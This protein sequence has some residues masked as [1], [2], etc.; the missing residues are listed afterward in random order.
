MKTCRQLSFLRAR[1]HS[2]NL[3]DYVYT[4][5]WEMLFG[6]ERGVGQLVLKGLKTLVD[7]HIHV[8]KGQIYV[9]E[10]ELGAW[11]SLLIKMPPLPIIAYALF[12]KFRAV[13]DKD[14]D[15]AVTAH[16]LQDTALISTKNSEL[17]ELARNPG[18]YDLHIHLN[19]ST[20][21]DWIWQ[22]ALKRPGRFARFV[23]R[24]MAAEADELF[25]QIDERFDR[26]HLY[27]LLYAASDIRYWMAEVCYGAEP[28]EVEPVSPLP[29]YF[30]LGHHHRR[31]AFP[32]NRHP[33][34]LFQPNSDL[35][36]DLYREVRLL[37][38]FYRKVET[39]GV[40]AY[41]NILH[42]YLLIQSLLNRLLVQQAEQNGFDQ[43]E[44]IT[45]NAMRDFSEESYYHRR[46]NQV[47]GMY[48]ED[49][50]FLEG[51][52]AP[53]DK[54][55]KMYN[56]LRTIEKEYDNYSR[57]KDRSNPGITAGE[58]K[59]RMEMKLVGHFIKK[60]VGRYSCCQHYQLRESLEKQA[61][62]L[63]E[64]RSM[65]PAFKEMIVGC[66][67]AGNELHAPP[68]VFAPVFRRM[69]DSEM[70]NFTF[71]VGEDFNHIVSGIRA[72]YETVCFLELCDGNRL[73]HATAL[74][75]EP[76][77]WKRRIGEK[78]VMRRA[79]HLD[80]LV[81]TW[82]LLKNK[83]NFSKE[84]VKIEQEIRSHSKRIYAE[85]VTPNLL[86]QAWE[87]RSLNPVKALV[88]PRRA[89]LALSRFDRE[90]LRLIDKV[91]AENPAA[92][93][94]FSKYHGK[95]VHDLMWGESGNSEQ[96]IEIKTD[97]ISEKAIKELQ[98]QVLK[99]LVE[100]DVAI[101]SM[102]TS[103]FR[104]SCYENY[105]EHHI[106]RWLNLEKELDYPEPKVCIC[107]DDPGIFATNIRNEYTH[108]QAMLNKKDVKGKDSEDF[109]AKLLHNSKKYAF[110]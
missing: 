67:A 101:E 88:D 50:A 76:L 70:S 99:V 14:K 97:F 108:V 72:V 74:G 9:K 27:R 100:S 6:E 61:R 44:R 83:S 23:C 102:P 85:E 51:R 49:V 89:K 24:E 13:S 66:D 7:K 105:D 36:S 63:I 98:W 34:I 29:T 62:L 21:A 58:E 28:S 38:D 33:R 106:T 31:L 52:F 30:S 77:L 4:N 64:M 87:M 57:G 103:N 35:N 107:S 96:Y 69:R 47:E 42:Y 16:L 25:M 91:K 1:Q 40:P 86:L 53:K 8:E 84:V 81:F 2:S 22:D 39:C 75:L 80:D 11:Q 15:L 3:P 90:E 26:N 60:K 5:H 10:G 46:F 41:G 104:I 110:R 45:R 17:D 59:K 55:M 56:L 93:A 71:H 94:I 92:L 82:K 32:R 68:E 78:I 79:N 12:D 54:G 19:G 48:S 73:G 109:I 20:E 18:F 43:F 65:K 37:V 95:K